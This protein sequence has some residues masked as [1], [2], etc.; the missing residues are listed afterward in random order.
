MEKSELQNPILLGQSGPLEGKRWLV[1]GS[2]TIGRDPA[3]E[4]I[5]PSRQVS[6]LHARL[7]VQGSGALLEDLDSRNGTFYL[8]KPV[9]APVLLSDGDTF[10]VAYTQQFVFFLSD[11]TLP[12]EGLGNRFLQGRL[13][14]DEGT[15]DVWLSEQKLAP[16]LSP[17]QFRLLKELYDHQ[18]QVVSREELF[19][20]VWGQ[21]AFGGVSEAAFDAL[22][23]R[24]RRRLAEVDPRHDYITT[25]RGYGLRLEDTR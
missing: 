11:A 12:L 10:S 6:R 9:H 18:G 14:L 15:K 19:S 20:A 13:R 7:T 17:E 23:R 24:L 2:L 21:E 25:V 1:I 22:V 5:V 3:C 8:G 16:P 4:V